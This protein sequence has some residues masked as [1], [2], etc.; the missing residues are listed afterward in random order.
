M[1]SYEIKHEIYIKFAFIFFIK[2]LFQLIFFIIKQKS[3]LHLYAYISQYIYHW[4][5]IQ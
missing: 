5:S 1:C 3:R 4:I 2:I